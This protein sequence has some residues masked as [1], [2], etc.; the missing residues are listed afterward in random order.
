MLAY[1]PRCD[2][3]HRVRTAGRQEQEAS[4]SVRKQGDQISS[5]YLQQGQAPQA[6]HMAPSVGD[7]MANI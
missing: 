4:P 3:V 6:P 7:Y 5:A 2:E 1:C